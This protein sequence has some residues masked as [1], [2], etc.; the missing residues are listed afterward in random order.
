MNNK[1]D[2]LDGI[3]ENEVLNSSFLTDILSV[4]INALKHQNLTN[5]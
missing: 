4:L 1:G 5:I 3:P 2:K